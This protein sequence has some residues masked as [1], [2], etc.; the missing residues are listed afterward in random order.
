MVRRPS[1]V[2]TAAL[3]AVR[4]PS[5]N[6]NR[7]ETLASLEKIATTLDDEKAQLW[8]NHD[9]PQSSTFRYARAYYE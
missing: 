4:V 3:V 1:I 2:L 7:D 8:I 5:M 9:K 6:V